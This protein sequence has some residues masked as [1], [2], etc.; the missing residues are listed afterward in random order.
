MTKTR[1][2]I[3]VVVSFAAGAALSL[4]KLAFHCRVPDSE[5]CVWGKAYRPIGLPI[6]TLVFGAGVFLALV[7]VMH[8]IRR[9]DS[10]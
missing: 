8:L 7:L 4:G 1:I 9:G 2:V 5:A 6:E 3:C 10:R